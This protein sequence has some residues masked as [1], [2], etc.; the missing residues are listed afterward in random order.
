MPG[1]AGHDERA[2]DRRA[3]HPDDVPRQALERVRLLQ[4]SALTVCGTSPTS[5]GMTSPRPTP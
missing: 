2:A 1:A 5:A 4:A 3:E